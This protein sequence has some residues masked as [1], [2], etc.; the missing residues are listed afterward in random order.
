MKYSEFKKLMEDKGLIVDRVQEGGNLRVRI[1][2]SY[3]K[4]LAIVD[5][6]NA[7]SYSIFSSRDYPEKLVRFVAQKCMELAFTDL[8]DREEEEKYYL[9]QKGVG[10]WSFLNFNID[11]QGYIVAG[12]KVNYTYKTQFTQ[13]EID[14][15]PECY[16]HPAVW[17][18]IKVDNSKDE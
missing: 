6:R 10:S 3:W 4:T 9:R 13:S 1:L 2:D 18:K 8:E 5:R 12:K 7:N 11:T 16:T 14:S 17:E 15:M